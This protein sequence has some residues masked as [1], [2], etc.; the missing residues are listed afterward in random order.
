MAGMIA[1]GVGVEHQREVRQREAGEAAK[2][3]LELA[4][5]ITSVKLQKIQ[6]RLDEAR[7]EQ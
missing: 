3:Q 7:E 4:L 5:K 1:V 6:K 2:A